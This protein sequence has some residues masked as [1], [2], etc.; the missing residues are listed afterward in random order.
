MKHTVD[1]YSF[2]DILRLLAIQ[3]PEE[4]LRTAF[5]LRNFV[6]KIREAGG[7]YAK[8]N[9]RQRAGRTA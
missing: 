3:D 2:T 9:P 5:H 1:R 4:K 7:K 8:S 6:L